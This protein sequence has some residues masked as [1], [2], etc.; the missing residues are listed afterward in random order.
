MEIYF[1]FPFLVEDLTPFG[2]VLEGFNGTLFFAETG[3]DER[4][5]L[6]AE[7]FA[8]VAADFLLLAVLSAALRRDLGR[9][10]V[11]KEVVAG[12]GST[13]EAEVGGGI[14]FAAS[15]Q[16]GKKSSIRWREIEL[17]RRQRGQ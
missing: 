16:F 15:C 4:F 11:F 9:G 8:E 7:G 17:A 2:A 3:L 1:F 10:S 6:D 5:L 13:L 14:F 12:F